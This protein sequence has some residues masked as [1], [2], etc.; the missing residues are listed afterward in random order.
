M[1]VVIGLDLSLTGLGLVA[2]PGDWGLDFGRVK[3]D[4]LETRPGEAQVDRRSA[5]AD[6]VVRWIEWA[7][8]KNQA[9]VWIEG[10]IT[11]RKY[12]NTVRSQLMLAG[13]V[14]HELR[15]RLGIDANFAEQSTARRLLLGRL[16][17]RDRKSYVLVEL[18]KRTATNWREDEY[19]AFVTANYGLRVA[20]LAYYAVAGLLERA[21]PARRKIRRAA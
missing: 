10:S 5:L 3:R 21:R 17:P 2:V 8:G 19:D 7:R 16:P 12:A 15:R 11:G 6:D 14:A 18:R 4:T 9:D 1:V 13:V 20:G